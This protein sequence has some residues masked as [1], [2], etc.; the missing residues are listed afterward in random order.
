LADAQRD[1]PD[2]GF[3]VSLRR[4]VECGAGLGMRIGLYDGTVQDGLQFV[5]QGQP[6]AYRIDDRE[7]AFPWLMVTRLGWGRVRVWDGNEDGRE[8]W[9]RISSLKR[10]LRRHEQKNGPFL[11]AQACLPCD[12][13][14]HEAAVADHHDDGHGRLALHGHN[15]LVP[16]LQRLLGLMR[17]DWPDILTL[18][19]FAVVIGVLSLATPLAVEALVNTVMFGRYQQPLLVLAVLLFVFLGFAA[20]LRAVT[21]VVVEIMQRRVMIRVVSDLG[22]RLARVR[23]FALDRVYGPELVN[24]YFD[25]MTVQKV[26]A[27]MLLDGISLVVSTVIGLIVLAFYHPFLLG[28]DLVLLM[29]LAV[30]VFGLGRGGVRTAIRESL[31]KYAIGQWLEDVIRN[32]TA[33]R[34][35]GGQQ[36]ALDRVD[37]LAV[38]YL[39]ARRQHFAI[40]MRQIVSAL[41]IQT[42]AS[43]A[44]LGLG[45]WLV[46]RGDL[47]P[48]QLVAAELIVTV[49]VGSVAKLGKQ[50]EAFY[51]LLASVDKLGHL[52]DLPIEPQGGI[53]AP[54]SA[55]SA[56]LRAVDMSLEIGGRSVLH[57]FQFD[58]R[59]GEVVALTGP[60]GSGKSL[61][62]QVFSG[63]RQ[64][65]SGW[66]EFDGV[67]MR[68]LSPSSVREQL[69]VARQLEVFEGTLAENV[70]LNRPQ[71]D[72]RD[73][74]AALELVDLHDEI[75]NLPD[76]LHTPLCSS[77]APLSQGQLA[78]L[79]LARAIASR[80]RLLLIDGLLDGLHPETLQ[81]VW[82]KLSDP[83]RPWTM[84]VVTNREEILSRSDRVVVMAPSEEPA[85][86]GSH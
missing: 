16:P 5:R 79:V 54:Q 20:A 71:L 62:L 48:G 29:M 42:I 13:A 40:L 52:F 77:G 27:T 2:D 34:L 64:P 11:V 24:R 7:A 59:A 78:R 66:V 47:T 26:V 61:L 23:Q 56:T 43:T 25:T 31:A 39:D 69:G 60:S 55:G 35:H 63:E 72:E 37:R 85:A 14:G 73:V 9:W 81:H 46:L 19:I 21:V 33:F 10:F 53:T 67:D 50:F 57:E 80:P 30:L 75:R 12:A 36:L 38:E 51:D 84:V 58:C 70:L 82:R 44:L 76:C 74:V 6:I 3:D 86:A 68:L 17:T 1:Q 28:F 49:V 8:R 22:Y 41:A 65:S 32:P 18:L 4:L 45:G 83:P 15:S